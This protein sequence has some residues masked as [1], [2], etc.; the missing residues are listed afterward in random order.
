MKARDRLPPLDPLRG[1]E[2]AARLQSFTRAAEE[3]N[4]TQ[5]AVSRQV[6]A[7]EEALG[8]ELFKRHPRHLELTESGRVL[9]RAT[10]EAFRQLRAA[11][12]TLREF[13]PRRRPVAIT[14]TVGIASLWLIPRLPAFQALCPQVDVRISANNAVADLAREDFDLAIRY[15]PDA[16]APA[17][18]TRLFGETVY[19]VC[20]PALLQGRAGFSAA[21]L[22]QQVLLHYDAGDSPLPWL[23]W[24]DWLRATGLAEVAPR[25]ALRFSN[26]DQVV[27]AAVAGQG[28]AL[29]RAPLVDRLLTD[30]SLVRAFAGEWADTARGYYLVIRP[31]PAR[32][33]VH[34]FVGWLLA[35]ARLQDATQPAA[36]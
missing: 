23:N 12:A 27:S 13:A 32:P 36:A 15:M 20:S 4:L 5:S 29:G 6:I 17:Q 34:Q 28:I 35:Q 3:L 9:S 14:T 30:G 31:Q 21:D 7:L 22:P 10:E 19:P 11:A 16:H 18:A 24:P 1:F 25:A 26:Y 2:A 8:C 33:E